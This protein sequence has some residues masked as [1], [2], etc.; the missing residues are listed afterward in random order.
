VPKLVPVVAGGEAA[1]HGV[2]EGR[3]PIAQAMAG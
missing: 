2:E 3:I 1:C